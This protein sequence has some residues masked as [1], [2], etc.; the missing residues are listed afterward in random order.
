MVMLLQYVMLGMRGIGP[1][2]DDALFILKARAEGAK[3]ALNCYE[4]HA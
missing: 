3:G 1:Q 2:V 4:K